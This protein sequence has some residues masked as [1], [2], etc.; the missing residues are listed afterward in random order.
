MTNDYGERIT[1]RHDPPDDL[2]NQ[3]LEALAANPDPVTPECGWEERL[4][5]GRVIEAAGDDPGGYFECSLWLR[6]WLTMR[7]THQ[8][9]R[10]VA[11]PVRQPTRPEPVMP[12]RTAC[13][14]RDRSCGE[15]G[16]DDS[17]TLACLP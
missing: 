13:G 6:G 10:D 4:V 11:I 9:L 17:R 5:A 8:V 14:S 3:S 7:R 12:R 15:D 1:R 2:F 16:Q